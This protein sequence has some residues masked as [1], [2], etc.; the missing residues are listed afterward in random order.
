M[1]REGIERII[2]LQEQH[3]QMPGL[4][5]Q[6]ANGSNNHSDTWLEVTYSGTYTDES[7]KD[8]VTSTSHVCSLSAQP[9]EEDRES[10]GG[11]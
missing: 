7:G 4:I 6:T 3:K 10:S 9:Q 8:A 5:K 1:D 11:C 2:D